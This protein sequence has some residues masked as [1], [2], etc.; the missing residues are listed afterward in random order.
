M[1]STKKKQHAKKPDEVIETRGRKSLPI[2][3]RRLWQI[4]QKYGSIRDCADWCGV[5]H[6]TIERRIKEWGY[7]NFASFRNEAMA[8]RRLSLKAH[9]FDR[10]YK[11]DK[12]LM[13]LLKNLSPEDFSERVLISRNE[14]EQIQLKI[15]TYEE[16]VKECG[17]PNAYPKQLEMMNFAIHG[18]DARLLLGSRGYGKTDYVTILGVAYDIYID[19]ITGALKLSWLLVTKSDDRNATIMKEI[20]KCLTINGVALEKDNS[21]A[22]RVI[23]LHGKDD[24]VSAITLR[25]GSKRGRHPKKIIM[26]DPV[27]EDDVQDSTR[28]IAKRTYDELYKICPHICIIGQ[29]VHK[30]DLY[31]ALRPLVKRMEVPH[32]TIPELDHDLVAQKLAGVSEESI[33]CSYHLIVKA[34]NPSPFENVQYIDEFPAEESIAFI[35][36]S[37][38]GMD[39]TAM[40]IGRGYFSGIAIQGK[41]WKKSWDNCIDEIGEAINKFKIKRIAFETNS[42]GDMPINLLR[43]RFPTVGIIGISNTANKHTRIVNAGIFAHSIYL[44]KTSDRIYIDQVTQY[45]YNARNDDAPDSLASLLQWIGFVKGK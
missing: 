25:S 34:E 28:R 43:Q 19:Y 24:S 45:E 35:D 15:K 37:F 36:P 11:S 14:P 20:A 13:F 22:V 4:A 26:D 12:V 32:G 33:S 3:K 29:P 30:A 9:L 1:A 44:A 39:Y 31:E 6:D 40:S 7:D 18:E 21:E 2:I 5:S 27:T 41:V 42:L 17:Y 16:F 23:G 38:K 10:A 8:A